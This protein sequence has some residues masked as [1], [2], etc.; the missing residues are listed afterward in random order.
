MKKHPLF[1]KG[2]STLFG[3]LIVA[4]TLMSFIHT[5]SANA[6]SAIAHNTADQVRFHDAPTRQN[7]KIYASTPS[8]LV[9]NGGPTMQ[10][11]STTYAIFWEPP[12]L[13]D[14]TATYVSATYNG[15]IEQYFND[16]SGSGL[17]NVNTQ[18]YDT[19][20]HIL[21]NSTFGGAWIDTSPYP[22][23]GCKD[24]FTPHGCLNNKQIQNEIVNALAV[25]GW[26]SG[27]THLF[28][29]FTS[30]GEGTC[31]DTGDCSFR[32]YCAY[33][34]GFNRSGQTMV[35]AAI[36]YE[37]TDLTNCGVTTS[38]NND[39]DADSSINFTSHE[40]MEAV[41]DPLV[42]AWRDASGNEIGD[43]CDYNFGPVTL[44]NGLAN[45]EW[46][47]HYYIVQQE[48]SNA[49]ARCVQYRSVS[50]SIYVGSDDDNMYALNANNGLLNWQTTTGNSITSSPTVNG[51]SI[52]VGSN[53]NNIYALHADGSLQWQFSTGGGVASSLAVS[54]KLLYSGSNDGNLYALNA[55]TGVKKWAFTLGGPVASSPT[56]SGKLLYIGSASG[57]I[58]ALNT[59]S[60]A[61]AW[62]YTTPGGATI[63]TRPAVVK[64]VVY[65]SADDGT[66]YAL[67]AT[68]GAFLWSNK[69]GGGISHSSPAIVKGILYIG[70]TD[71]SLYALNA[72]TGATLW[73]YATG[74]EVV[75]SP[76]VNNGNVYIGSWD[77]YVYALN[78][79]SGMLIWR[80]ATT[81]QVSSSPQVID[82]LL[83]IGSSD[84]NVYALWS[85]DGAAI[86]Q[87]HTGGGVESSPAASFTSF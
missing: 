15:L 33:H 51:S 78:A 73:S 31:N 60:G 22:A 53:D 34:F 47:G 82:G 80:S 67:N 17:Y 45:E 29:V 23:S 35:A 40:H 69:P 65:V 74:N 42:T 57:I 66:I 16:V 28:V 77:S 87:Y 26:T 37:G 44:D 1:F 43:K 83:Y 63:D 18:Y 75:S 19:T 52:Y 86:W 9:Y 3:M 55:T 36:P 48:W 76:L 13:Q 72:T 14:G 7:A 56:V 58:Y 32:N 38:P 2:L 84:Q 4:F 79:A 27:L 10:S 68:S 25:N 85:D 81:G 41:T 30:W 5:H 71:N 11:T 21:N 64:G 24:S 59:T 39:P 20:G 49:L 12:T 54:G 50:G 46:N 8:L 6:A 70:S 61:I 62:S